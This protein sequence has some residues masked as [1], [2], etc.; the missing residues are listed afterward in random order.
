MARLVSPSFVCPW[1]LIVS[2]KR[3]QAW[4]ESKWITESQARTQQWR[5]GQHS[6]PVAWIWNEGQHIPRDAIQG[7]EERGEAL[8]ICRAYRDVRTC[9][10]AVKGVANVSTVTRVESVRFS[11]RIGNPD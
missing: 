6:A 7:G 2:Q 5:A 1:R 4:S 11:L 9:N 8:Y 10:P 3:A